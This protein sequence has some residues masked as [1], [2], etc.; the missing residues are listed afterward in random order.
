M[1]VVFRKTFEQREWQ[2]FSRAHGCPLVTNQLR[3]QVNL[4][5]SI[6]M[7]SRARTLLY[8]ASCRAAVMHV[9]NTINYTL[10]QSS[11]GWISER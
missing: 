9:N 3:C 7:H 5:G 4:I 10:G 1:A 8:A 2:E 6:R 11:N